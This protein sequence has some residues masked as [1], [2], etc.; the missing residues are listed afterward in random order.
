VPNLAQAAASTSSICDSPEVN[1]KLLDAEKVLRRHQ[2][3]S[4]LNS[5]F[6][7][8]LNGDYKT[9]DAKIQTVLAEFVDS[10]WNS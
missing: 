4:S 10:F 5:V 3:K 6:F 9:T 8:S 7:T 1:K 2:R